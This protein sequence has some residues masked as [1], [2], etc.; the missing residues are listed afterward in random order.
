MSKEIYTPSLG[1]VQ[2]ALVPKGNGTLDPSRLTDAQERDLSHLLNENTNYKMS[3]FLTSS[4]DG[5]IAG[6]ASLEKSSS[7]MNRQSRSATMAAASPDS[8][9][10]GAREHV[11]EF[12]SRRSGRYSYREV[13]E[14]QLQSL[15]KSTRAGWNTQ[16]A[17]PSSVRSERSRRCSST[18][19]RACQ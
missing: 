18:R 11:R 7:R 4:P 9:S 3:D 8:A 14:L 13:L 10:A 15:R 5:C 1:A 2:A 6:T 12:H 16:T 17:P 19:P